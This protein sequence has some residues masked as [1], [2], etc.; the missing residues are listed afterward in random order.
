[1]LQAGDPAAFFVGKASDSVEQFS[2]GI[3]AS[4]FGTGDDSEEAEVLARLMQERPIKPDQL[5]SL[6]GDKDAPLSWY[7]NLEN[8]RQVKALSLRYNCRAK[9]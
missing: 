4:G 8:P 1:M 5:C 3:L 9:L 7:L 6:P 2:A